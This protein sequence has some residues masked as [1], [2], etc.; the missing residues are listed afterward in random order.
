MLLPI[1]YNDSYKVGI[2]CD[3]RDKCSFLL[4]IICFVL[5]FLLYLQS[6]TTLLSI[7]HFKK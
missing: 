5:I 7:S 2:C 1:G 6:K 4:I 3:F